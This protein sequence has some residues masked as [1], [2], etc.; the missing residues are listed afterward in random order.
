MAFRRP[1]SLRDALVMAEMLFSPNKIQADSV[2]HVEI[3]DL[4]HAPVPRYCIPIH[5]KDTVLKGNT[6]CFT[7]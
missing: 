4:I 6:L 3:K 7:T 5:F 1:R 2:N